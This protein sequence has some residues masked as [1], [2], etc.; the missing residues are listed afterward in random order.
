LRFSSGTFTTLVGHW[1]TF[2]SSVSSP[3]SNSISSP[4]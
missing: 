1:I 2:R 3:S 4:F